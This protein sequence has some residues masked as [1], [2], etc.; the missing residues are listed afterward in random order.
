MDW[1]PA[2]IDPFDGFELPPGITP[3]S[4]RWEM[5]NRRTTPMFPEYANV[6]NPET[7]EAEKEITKKYTFVSRR[8]HAIDASRKVEEVD[9]STKTEARKFFSLN[10]TRPDEFVYIDR[11]VNQGNT[12]DAQNIPLKFSYAGF[13][14]RSPI[15]LLVALS[16]TNVISSK[17]FRT[18]AEEISQKFLTIGAIGKMSKVM[19]AQKL[20]KNLK[21]VFTSMLKNKNSLYYRMFVKYRLSLYDQ[22]GYTDLTDLDKYS[23]ILYLPEI[24]KDL[25]GI[26]KDILTE[27]L[28]VHDSKEEKLSKT[29]PISVKKPYWFENDQT[30]KPNTNLEPLGEYEIDIH[31]D[32][33]PEI[34][35]YKI[36]P[37]TNTTDFTRM[38]FSERPYASSISYNP[39]IRRGVTLF[40]QPFK[41]VIANSEIFSEE[42]YGDT[43]T[44]RKIMTCDMITRS[45]DYAALNGFPLPPIGTEI[46]THFADGSDSASILDSQL[47]LAVY[48]RKKRH[49][50]LIPFPD[51]SYGV[52]TAGSRFSISDT[53]VMTWDSTKTYIKD[54]IETKLPLIRRDKSVFFKGATYSHSAIREHM[55]LLSGKRIIDPQK[56]NETLIPEGKFIIDIPDR[57]GRLITPPLTIPQMGRYRFIL[58]LPVYGTLSTRLK[59]IILTKSIA[60]RIMFVEI[61]YNEE[62]KKWYQIDP[63]DIWQT[64]FDTFTPFDIVETI[65][66]ESYIP[67]KSLSL[68]AVS[69]LNKESR[70]RVITQVGKVY[71]QYNNDISKSIGVVNRASNI[72]DLLTN[73]DV[74]DYIYKVTMKMAKMYG[75]IRNPISSTEI[76]NRCPPEDPTGIRQRCLPIQ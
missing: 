40:Q 75:H 11:R 52:F 76:I 67:H 34:V 42:I 53:S 61:R 10:S 45:L 69:Q 12:W 32:R 59:F 62:S 74:S 56:R 64:Y 30:F 28:E 29:I 22:W 68:A 70:L 63:N 51:Y 44:T 55:Y 18:F 26:I 65:I 41:V 60:I 31:M 35:I 16:H 8:L 17:E 50:F 1:I 23:G 20:Q 25:D 48:C 66:G 13:H 15:N 3:D 49:K 21:T 36:V 24:L 33:G 7:L 71:K 57:E 4:A 72:V 14:W 46:F 43:P 47:P 73:D 39:P 2:I 19:D 58:D 9:V 37:D 54:S 38:N 5:I 27:W 6:T